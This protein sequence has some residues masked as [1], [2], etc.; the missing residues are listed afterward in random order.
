MIANK[1][2]KIKK[3]RFFPREKV[4]GKME[5]RMMEKWNGKWSRNK[6]SG[7]WKRERE[8]FSEPFQ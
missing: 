1:W 8:R 6:K 2:G 5:N 7:K 4:L 3:Q